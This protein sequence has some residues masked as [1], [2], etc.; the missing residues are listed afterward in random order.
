MDD[1]DRGHYG[2]EHYDKALRLLGWTRLDEV[3]ELHDSVAPSAAVVHFVQ[4]ERAGRTFADLND[5]AVA[6]QT[7]T[8]CEQCYVIA[9]LSVPVAPDSPDWH[10]PP[11]QT[12]W[13]IVDLGPFPEK[14]EPTVYRATL[15][16]AKPEP[17]EKPLA[18][19]VVKLVWTV[20]QASRNG[21]KAGAS[22]I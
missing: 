5:A 1:T 15:E 17:G 9:D 19:G 18:P 8:I 4:K 12:G 10:Q 22:R 6:C 16:P 13:W 14:V 11:N 7:G 21:E 2:H 20:M 3:P